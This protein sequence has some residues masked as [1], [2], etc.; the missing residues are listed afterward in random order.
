MILNISDG[1]SLCNSRRMCYLGGCSGS[2][3]VALITINSDAHAV[4]HAVSVDSYVSRLQQCSVRGVCCGLLAKHLLS[5]RNILHF[6]SHWLV[7]GHLI[8]SA[9]PV[10]LLA[11]W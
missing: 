5:L 1:I 8:S 6:I 2:K 9:V 3:T 10:R 11:Q 4:S 7:V